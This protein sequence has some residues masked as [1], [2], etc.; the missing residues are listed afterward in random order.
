MSNP[1]IE[2]IQL[3]CNLLDWRYET[4]ELR[5][6]FLASRAR[7]EVRSVFLQGL[8]TL[9]PMMRWP[10]LPVSYDPV[11]LADFIASQSRRWATG[12]AVALSIRFALSLEWVDALVLGGGHTRT[13]PQFGTD[14]R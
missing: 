4:P 13:N 6:A 8:L 12:D 3:A 14:C 1:E 7:V 11:G 2:V 5:D 9:N 10:T